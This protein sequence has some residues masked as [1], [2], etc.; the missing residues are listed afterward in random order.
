M[1]KT[2]ITKP[3]T[4]NTLSSKKRSST[5]LPMTCGLGTVTAFSKNTTDGEINFTTKPTSP[6]ISQG[7]RVS[8]NSHKSRPYQVHHLIHDGNKNIT[9]VVF[10]PTAYSC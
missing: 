3:Y 6:S 4:H 9:P 1:E 2:K 7:I 8:T 5:F 10:L